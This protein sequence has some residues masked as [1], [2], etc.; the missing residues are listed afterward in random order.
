MRGRPILGGA[1]GVFLGLFVAYDLFL[2]KVIASDSA[3]FLVL[4]LISMVAGIGLGF[5]APL[6]RRR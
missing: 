5:W 3:A 6:H 2:F 1:A 4:P